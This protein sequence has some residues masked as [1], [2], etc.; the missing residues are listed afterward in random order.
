MTVTRALERRK[1][2]WCSTANGRGQEE[3]SNVLW[4][5]FLARIACELL[6]CDPR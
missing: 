3:N 5:M 1:K 6:N 2:I 4:W